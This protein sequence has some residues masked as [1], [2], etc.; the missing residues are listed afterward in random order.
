MA[1]LFAW[2]ALTQRSWGLL[3]RGTIGLALGFGLAGFYLLPAAYE[4]RWVNIG[5]ALSSGLLPSENFLFTQP[6][7]VEHTWFNWIS[8]LCALALILLTALTAFA[9]RRFSP[10][11]TIS[12]GAKAPWGSA[13]LVLGLVP[14]AMI[15]RLTPP[16]CTLLPKMPFLP[17]P[18][19]LIS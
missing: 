18:S 17:F 13:L 8:S 19:P 6:A 5:Q 4:Q 16:L 11:A 2:A 1:L 14:T 15:L 9:S 12:T 3:P 10:G 7:D